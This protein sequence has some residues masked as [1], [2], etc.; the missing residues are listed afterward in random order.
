M[1]PSSFFARCNADRRIA[2]TELNCNAA[3]PKAAQTNPPSAPPP[4]PQP[5][6]PT[7]KPDYLS[8]GE[9]DA[10]KGLAVELQW[11]NFWMGGAGSIIRLPTYPALAC[12]AECGWGGFS[13]G[14]EIL[15]FG[16]DIG[17]R[18]CLPLLP[19]FD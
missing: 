17:V 7:G 13:H 15:Q 6:T 11:C 2:A 3:I 19:A 12:A 14:P 8:V 9:N 10:G 16:S 5:S 1:Q 4:A 18:E